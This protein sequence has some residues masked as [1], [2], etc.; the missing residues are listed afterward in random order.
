MEV[1]IRH[2]LSYPAVLHMWI[3]QL[4]NV[5]PE[6]DGLIR[7]FIRVEEEH[8]K[9]VEKY[10]KYM[11]YPPSWIWTSELQKLMMTVENI[12]DGCRFIKEDEARIAYLK[13]ADY[14]K[15]YFDKHMMVS[16]NAIEYCE[17]WNDLLVDGVKD[18]LEALEL[19]HRFTVDVYHIP[20]PP[21]SRNWSK[22]GANI[23][24]ESAVYMWDGLENFKTVAYY[25]TMWH[26]FFHILLRETINDW[27]LGSLN[28]FLCELVSAMLVCKYFLS[29]WRWQILLAPKT[30][31]DEG[32]CHIE[33]VIEEFKHARV[34]REILDKSILLKVE[35]P[36]LKLTFEGILTARKSPYEMEVDDEL[37]LVDYINGKPLFRL[38]H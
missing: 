14:L 13:L 12:E 7:Q 20:Y 4:A 1:E 19:K 3:L 15:P 27:K 30:S 21:L 17:Y 33:T 11:G 28:E 26:E 25:L 18:M 16:E 36:S 5:P 8:V 35:S 34:E 31:V 23:P 32:K 22:G 9:L 24:G 38:T 37:I 29:K 6:A 2:R 10:A